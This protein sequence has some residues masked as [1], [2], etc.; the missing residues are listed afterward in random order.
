[1]SSVSILI[2]IG[3]DTDV[4]D[5]ANAAKKRPE[6][7]RSKLGGHVTLCVDGDYPS[8]IDDVQTSF[9]SSCLTC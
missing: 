1:M 7:N 5:A 4:R 9:G 3:E 2:E 6:R 8:S